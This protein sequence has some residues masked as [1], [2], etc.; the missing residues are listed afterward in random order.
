MAYR[1]ENMKVI[2]TV[3]EEAQTYALLE[4]DFKS[5]ILSTL[6]ELKETRTMQTK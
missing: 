3:P 1:K 4:K 6:Q 5:T 2:N